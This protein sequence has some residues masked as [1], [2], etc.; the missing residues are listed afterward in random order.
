MSTVH[1]SGFGQTVTRASLLPLAIFTA[2][3][4]YLL[5]HSLFTDQ[6]PASETPSTSVVWKADYSKKYP[7]CVSTVLWPDAEKPVALVVVDAEGGTAKVTRGQARLLASS[8][9]MTRTIGACR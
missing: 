5:P 2:V 3:A 8:G 6:P 4:A 9:G 1:A 7:G